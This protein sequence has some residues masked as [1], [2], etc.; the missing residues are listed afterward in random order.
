[1]CFINYFLNLNH[2]K[3]EVSNIQSRQKLV[4]N[5]EREVEEM[6]PLFERVKNKIDEWD[7]LNSQISKLREVISEL[8]SRVD[9]Q[10][11]RIINLEETKRKVNEIE[12]EFE[13]M[14]KDLSKLDS[15]IDNA[16]A[17]KL[18]ELEDR[19][20]G[21]NLE[22]E[23]MKTEIRKIIIP[24]SSIAEILRRVDLLEEEM[25][26]ILRSMKVRKKTKRIVRKRKKK[27]RR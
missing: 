24:T 1:M 13:I 11:S 3:L 2:I 8:K 18:F 9:S 12:S 10:E 4:E 19:T 5:V 20:S 21:L 15:K 16:V 23:K 22:I 14:R 25:E 26:E 7:L 6:R 17:E 27:S